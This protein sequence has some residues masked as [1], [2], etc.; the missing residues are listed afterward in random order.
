[1]LQASVCLGFGVTGHR[2][3]ARL[4]ASRLSTSARSLVDGLLKDCPK[5]Y[6]VKECTMAGVADWADVYCRTSCSSGYC[7]CYKWHFNSLK[8]A[9]GEVGPYIIFQTSNNTK[10]INNYHAT[11]PQRRDALM[12]TIHLF[13]DIHQ[14]L[15]AGGR[16]GRLCGINGGANS[17]KPVTYNPHLSAH[18]LHNLWDIDLVTSAV[19]LEATGSASNDGRSTYDQVTADYEDRYLSYLQTMMQ[20]EWKKEVSKWEKNTDPIEWA[21]EADEY[22]EDIFKGDCSS[23]TAY[24]DKVKE[25]SERFQGVNLGP[26]GNESQYYE[27]NHRIIS[28]RLAAGGVRLAVAL[29]KLV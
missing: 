12:F 7:Y 11:I 1:M 27:K 2:I 28:K 29:N 3:V 19:Y 10:E 5:Y 16:A 26:D 25:L 21:A 24:S 8:G 4:A 14:P 17:V 15:H 20:S 6:G 18:N 22:V 9:E 23:A 13:G